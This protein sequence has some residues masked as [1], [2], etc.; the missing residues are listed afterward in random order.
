MIFFPWSIDSNNPQ[1]TVKYDF[2][3]YF[4]HTKIL[5]SLVFTHKFPLSDNPTDA[6]ISQL[7]ESGIEYVA[8]Y[9]AFRKGN[10]FKKSFFN[11]ISKLIFNSL[12][13]KYP[14]IGRKTCDLTEND[15]VTSDWIHF[16]S[17]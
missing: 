11:L 16:S 14:D 9:V 4:S 8:G 10:I 2:N 13:T 12:V 3:N 1:K 17:R 5:S 6:S 7:N 15:E